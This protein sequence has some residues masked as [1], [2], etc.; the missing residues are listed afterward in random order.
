MMKMKNYLLVFFILII[1]IHGNIL[2]GQ[3]VKIVHNGGKWQLSVKQQ[4][5][6][7][8]GV[9]GQTY[10]EKVKEYGGNSIRMGYR[11]EGLDKVWQLGLTV[12][13]DLPA[14]AERY[15]M[16]YDDTAAV[17]KQTENIVGIVRKTKDHPAVLMWTIGNEL[18][19]IPGTLPFN[20]KVWNAVNDAARAIKAIDPD[21]PVMTVIGISMMEK[22][23]DIV[24]RCP[25]I[26][27]LGVNTYGSIYTL[28]DTL[29]KYGWTKPYIISEWG[30]DGY[31]EVKKTSWKAPYE[32]TGREK[33]DCYQKKYKAAIENENGQCLGS[34]VF[35]WSGFKQETTH[36]WFCMF[37]K[38]GLESP[39]VGLMHRMWTGNEFSNVAPIVDSLN[40]DRF[41]RYQDIFVKPGAKYSAKV[42]SSDADKDPL[43]YKWEIRPEAVYASYAGQGEKVP[44]PVQGLITEEKSAISFISP[45][46]KGAYRLFVYVFDGKGHFS[47]ANLPFMVQ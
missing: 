6:F 41:V 30:P 18:D 19:Y 44:E 24:K 12:L 45:D 39:L 33:Y 25:D 35:Y 5:Y 47:T 27:L 9:I 23:T 21:H 13:V 29:K 22:V 28:P 46:K 38:D 11:K 1:S 14:N 16:N 15:G 8:K 40:I 42:A 20:P 32:Q 17:R 37:N 10:L 7:I 43:T 26:D 4:P 31:W 34:Y 3:E 36:T 2:L